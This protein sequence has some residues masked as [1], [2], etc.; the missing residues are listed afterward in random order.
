MSP[1]DDCDSSPSLSPII[2]IVG[3]EL[4]KL[5]T[6]HGELLKNG[7]KTAL[8]RTPTVPKGQERIRLSF[9]TSATLSFCQSDSPVAALHDWPVQLADLLASLVARLKSDSET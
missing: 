2:S 6:L 3:L 9:S 7:Y 1:V 4:N 8:I 5:T